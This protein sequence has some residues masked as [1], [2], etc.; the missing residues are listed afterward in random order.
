MFH[1]NVILKHAATC[2]ADI[3]TKA[4]TTGYVAEPV[5]IFRENLATGRSRGGCTWRRAVHL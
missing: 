3:L 2:N 4:V 1:D 5:L